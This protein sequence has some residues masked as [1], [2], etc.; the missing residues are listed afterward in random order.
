MVAFLEA[1]LVVVASLEALLA[2]V[3]PLGFF[4]VFTVGLLLGWG[5]GGA[6][7]S[8][9]AGPPGGIK[10]I[11]GAGPWTGGACAWAGGAGPMAGGAGAMA[12]GGCP[13]PG[14]GCP[15]A[16]ADGCF[17]PALGSCGGA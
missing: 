17:R 5:G 7:C 6:G 16:G 3:E 1:L 12:G 2:V 15:D 13:E 14:G 11:G 4:V 9:I 10:A 8:R